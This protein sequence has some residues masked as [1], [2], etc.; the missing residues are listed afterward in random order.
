MLLNL[1]QL[2]KLKLKGQ[3]V[4]IVISISKERCQARVSPSVSRAFPEDRKCWSSSSPQR[5]YLLSFFIESITRNF[6]SWLPSL[7]WTLIKQPK[8][9][10][11][12]QRN[13]SCMLI[14]TWVALQD[15]N[16]WNLYSWGDNYIFLTETFSEFLNESRSTLNFLQ[17][18]M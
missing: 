2:K 4:Q 12:Q 13:E 7:G 15:F 5:S 8:T 9:E 18:A 16:Y 17:T 11:L 10:K 6:L 1:L 3:K 14:Q